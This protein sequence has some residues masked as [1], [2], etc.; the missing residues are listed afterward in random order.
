MKRK[1]EE[2]KEEEEEG[3]EGEGDLPAPRHRRVV[4]SSSSFARQLGLSSVGVC[5]SVVGFS[6][7][8]SGKLGFIFLISSFSVLLH[9]FF[10][11]I[12][13]IFS[14]IILGNFLDFYCFFFKFHH[15]HLIQVYYVDF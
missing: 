4:F 2:E 6:G 13:E 3:E 14:R 10:S 11:R 5:L 1:R 15:E 12:F 7:S 8:P 9:F